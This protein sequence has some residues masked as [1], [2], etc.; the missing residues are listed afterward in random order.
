MPAKIIVLGLGNILCGDDG[1]GS[2]A[3]QMLAEAFSFPE[4]CAVIDGGT[5][6]QL[7]YGIVEEAD[8]LLLIDAVDLG[9]PAGSI[10]LRRGDGIPVWL[11]ARK[12]SAHQNSFAEVIAL[13]KL[14]NVLPPDI[15]LI[16]FQAVNCGFGN[17][18][19]P[20]ASERLP[21]A[22]HMALACL[23][24]WGTLPAKK[25]ASAGC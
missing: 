22:I 15:R 2:H 14:K 3:A 11:A 1:F 10:V 23:E 12:L 6:G 5:Q 9:L 21:E 24:E 18:L 19:S 25:H 17:A 13:A 4:N 8:R 7:L 20:K 16:G